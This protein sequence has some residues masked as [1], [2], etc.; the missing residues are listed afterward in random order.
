MKKQIKSIK[1]NKALVS[2]ALLFLILGFIAGLLYLISDI[3]MSFGLNVMQGGFNEATGIENAIM[4]IY[5]I[6]IFAPIFDSIFGIIMTLIIVSTY[7]L[8]AKKFP[9]EIEL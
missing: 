3:K 4:P 1:L 2:M 6:L 8:I 7:N 5:A 9:I